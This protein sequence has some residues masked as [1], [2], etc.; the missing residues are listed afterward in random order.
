MKK[1]LF[2]INTLGYGGA[3]RA[4]LNLLQELHSKNYEIS[5]FVLTG[6]GELIRDLP[7]N[8]KLLNQNYKPV[9][10]L[11][12]RAEPISRKIIATNLPISILNLSV[13]KIYANII[14]YYGKI[15]KTIF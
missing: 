4:M 11:E 15:I 12:K 8:V 1:L 9:S 2:I 13:K 7:E 6:Q 10:V 14:A 3:E 5:L